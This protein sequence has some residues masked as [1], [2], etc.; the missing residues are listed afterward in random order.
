MFSPSVEE[1][2]ALLGGTPVG[3]ETKRELRQ[4]RVQ[5][6]VAAGGMWSAGLDV[7][8]TLFEAGEISATLPCDL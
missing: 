6:T 1:K 2:T 3:R 4:V 5:Y 7:T 8:V